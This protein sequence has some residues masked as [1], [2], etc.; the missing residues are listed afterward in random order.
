M[1][2]GLRTP[3]STRRT[4]RNRRY[5]AN[6]ATRKLQQPVISFNSL[7]SRV[8]SLVIP[9]QWKFV[10]LEG[11]SGSPIR[12][13]IFLYTSTYFFNVSLASTTNHVRYDAQTS[14]LQFDYKLSPFTHS[15]FTS[16]LEL[17]V[18]RFN[19]PVFSKVKFQGKGYYVYK[20][21]RNTIAPQFGYAHRV[22][23]YAQAVS[24]K[25]LSKTKVM[26]FGLSAGDVLAASSSLK[27]VKPINIFTGRGVRFARQIV[28]RKTGK[29]SS[30]R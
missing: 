27:S 24:V 23:V 17:L 6:L 29:V 14:Q 11:A 7:P 16:L 9:S 1:W 10:L 15:A 21:A 13:S 3:P 19:R 5:R 8:S 2:Y 18:S 30:Y 22:Y 25:F 12:Y 4:L 26:I 28:Y 20:N